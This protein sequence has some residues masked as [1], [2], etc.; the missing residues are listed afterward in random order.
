MGYFD[1]AYFD[2]A[3]FDCGPAPS[4]GGGHAHGYPHRAW[5]NRNVIM[6]PAPVWLALAAR[7]RRRIEDETAAAIL[8]EQKAARRR[9]QRIALA[10]GV[11]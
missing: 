2:P 11:H 3:Y 10:L 9:R 4:V 1:A 8:R 7:K 5:G 6:P